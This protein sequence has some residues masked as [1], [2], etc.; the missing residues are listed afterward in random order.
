MSVNMNHPMYRAV[1]F[2]IEFRRIF[3]HMT[4]LVALSMKSPR[5]VSNKVERNCDQY[6][7]FILTGVMKKILI[8]TETN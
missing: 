4:E 6:D 2:A 7:S 8:H 5:K 1:L 3:K